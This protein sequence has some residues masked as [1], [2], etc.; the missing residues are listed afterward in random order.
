[1]KL[2]VGKFLKIMESALAGQESAA[3][4]ARRMSLPYKPVL[5]VVTK[6][7]KVDKFLSAPVKLREFFPPKYRSPL[8]KAS[9]HA[10]VEFVNQTWHGR[11]P[12]AKLLSVTVEFALAI[13]RRE[14]PDL[15]ISGD[16]LK[17]IRDHLQVQFSDAIAELRDAQAVQ[18]DVVN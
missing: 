12:P 8:V 2:S 13:F 6:I 10:V 14:C 4:I 16:Q 17:K 3:V 9:P 18:S 15:E 7:R 11:L 5:R 1:M